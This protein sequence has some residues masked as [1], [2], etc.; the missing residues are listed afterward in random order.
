MKQVVADL[1]EAGFEL[2]QI[3]INQSDS[4]N[5]DAQVVVRD[6]NVYLS[7]TRDRGQYNVYFTDSRCRRLVPWNSVSI[8]IGIATVEQVAVLPIQRPLWNRLKRSVVN[9]TLGLIKRHEALIQPRFA[10]SVVSATFEQ[11]ER[12]AFAFGQ[13]YVRKLGAEDYD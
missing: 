5:F 13:A 3:V 1:K 4:R 7:F 2:F 9:E 8:L 10:S 12:I 6:R 11:L